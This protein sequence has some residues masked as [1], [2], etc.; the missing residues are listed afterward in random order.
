MSDCIDPEEVKRVIETFQ[1]AVD[2]NMDKGNEIAANTYADA[3]QFTRRELLEE[4][5]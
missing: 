2:R 5:A 4:E 3:A 1:K